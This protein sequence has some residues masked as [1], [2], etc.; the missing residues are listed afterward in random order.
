MKKTLTFVLLSILFVHPVFAAEEALSQ[1]ELLEQEIDS[2]SEGWLPNI[3]RF[4]SE[5]G[6]CGEIFKSNTISS[7]Y[8]QLVKNLSSPIETRTATFN[9]QSSKIQGDISA[10]ELEI[11]ALETT[12]EQKKDEFLNAIWVVSDYQSIADEIK[13]LQALSLSKRG[14][15]N[16]KKKELAS[17][18][19]TFESF[20]TLSREEIQKRF[21]YNIKLTCT[22]WYGK[23]ELSDKKV[24]DVKTF[25]TSTADGIGKAPKKPSKYKKVLDA[26]NVLYIKNPKT[27]EKLLKRLEKVLPKISKSNKNYELL[28]DLKHHIEDLIAEENSDK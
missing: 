2:L 19:A 23:V 17:I 16:I 3:K 15:I 6:E 9:D 14:E 7:W 4:L 12:I 28:V 5:R 18:T 22:N 10:I 26:V 24:L 13:K 1:N 27:V 8:L 11:D 20:P 25:E 21:E